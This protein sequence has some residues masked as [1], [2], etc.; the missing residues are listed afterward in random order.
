MGNHTNDF[1]VGIT[2][3]CSI[4]SDLLPVDSFNYKSFVIVTKNK[5]NIENEMVLSKKNIISKI[6]PPQV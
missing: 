3:E 4:F 2:N 6:T 1:F 5:T